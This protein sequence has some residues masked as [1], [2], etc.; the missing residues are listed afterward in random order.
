MLVD[1]EDIFSLNVTVMS[2]G[3]DAITDTSVG[4]ALS[5]AMVLCIVAVLLKVSVIVPIC[6]T[7]GV[8]PV[9]NRVFIVSMTVV[10]SP[11]RSTMLIALGGF[12]PNVIR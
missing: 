1:F 11:E 5:S 12:E 2:L 4:G 6:S 9:P 7:N 8:S 10:A 3:L